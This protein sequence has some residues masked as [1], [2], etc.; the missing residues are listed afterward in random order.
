MNRRTCAKRDSGRVTLAS[1]ARKTGLHVTTV[2]QVLN[3]RK[4]CWASPE[5]RKKVEETA[6]KMGYRP[7][8]VARGLRSGRSFVIG[9][10][11]PG[12]GIGSPH[13]RVG[14]LTDAAAQKGY[15]VTVSSHPNDSESEDVLIRRLLDRGV[16]GIAIYPVDKGPHHELRRIV[17]SGFP[18]V[19]FN[20]KV[21]LDF[22]TDDISPDYGEVGGLQAQ[23]VIDSGRRRICLAN[24][25]PSAVINTVREEA[26]RKLL[27]KAGMPS[28]LKMVLPADVS[29]EFTDEEIYEKAIRDFVRENN[30]KFDAVISH[31][32]IASLVIRVLIDSGLKV[33]RDVAVVGAGNGVLAIYGMIPMSSVSTSDDD[34]GARAFEMLIDGINGTRT[35]EKTRVTSK[36]VLIPR[37]SSVG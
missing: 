5:T 30:G 12:F 18:V 32:T 2:S 28:P 9:Y 20:G 34:A 31:D 15:T 29:R 33:P 11:A 7:N 24:T 16:D 25:S 36:S 13:T 26:V 6:L 14:G 19:T 37:K 27:E 23:H 1:I 22:E 4:N 35:G 21:L 8:L 10:M 3:K 17:K